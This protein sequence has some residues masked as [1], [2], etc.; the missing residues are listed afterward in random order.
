MEARNKGQCPSSQLIRTNWNTP[1][2]RSTP[3]KNAKNL[4]A[5]R[6]IPIEVAIFNDALN[7]FFRP[8]RIN[9]FGSLG[10]HCVLREV[11]KNRHQDLQSASQWLIRS[12]DLRREHL[13]ESLV[14]CLSEKQRQSYL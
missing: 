5:I 9:S 8:L 11:M 6:Y 3:D 2:G 14:H 7:L 12:I 10:L 4:T 1:I 13:A